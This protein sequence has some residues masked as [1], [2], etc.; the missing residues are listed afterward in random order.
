MTTAEPLL[1]KNLD[2]STEDLSYYGSI[3]GAESSNSR[4]SSLVN[5]KEKMKTSFLSSFKEVH[6]KLGGAPKQKTL[7]EKARAYREENPDAW[8]K[9]C[10]EKEKKDR[11]LQEV[12][13]PD[14]FLESYYEKI[15][16]IDKEE[17]R[18][19]ELEKLEV[20]K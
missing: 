9:K 5:T 4:F 3:S 16:E 19:K 2:V 17:K 6:S 18:K 7:L 12:Y 14:P 11:E 20:S 1:T 15:D 10:Q 13:M 8:A